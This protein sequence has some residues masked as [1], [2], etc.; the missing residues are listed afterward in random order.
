VPK[1]VSV[2]LPVVHVILLS[3]AFQQ[4]PVVGAVIVP[5]AIVGAVSSLMIVVVLAEPIVS[6][7]PGSGP[8]II[9]RKCI[10]P[11]SVNSVFAGDDVKSASKSNMVTSLPISPARIV[12]KPLGI[13]FTQV[14]VS[15]MTASFV[16][17][18]CIVPPIN[19]ELF[20]TGTVTSM[21]V[22]VLL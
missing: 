9:A 1:Y 6:H 3:P 11:P 2:I 16:I 8:V 4:V 21:P 7:S 18:T 14:V 17:C 5:V 19:N 20:G 13:T 22:F 10:F 12:C 15:S